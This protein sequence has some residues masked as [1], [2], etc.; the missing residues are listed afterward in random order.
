MSCRLFCVR[1]LRLLELPPMFSLSCAVLRRPW[2]RT[3]VTA[4]FQRLQGVYWAWTSRLPVTASDMF[5]PGRRIFS[6]SSTFYTIRCPSPIFLIPLLLGF[7]SRSP[8]MLV[9]CSFE[10]K[11]RSG[12][13]T[14]AGPG[15][16]EPADMA[17]PLWVRPCCTCPSYPALTCRYKL[18]T[19][20]FFF[21]FLNR[22]QL[23]GCTI[24]FVRA[25]KISR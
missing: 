11:C 6:S 16:R 17:F 18:N 7:L 10:C 19:E 3:G 23:S 5:P 13:D 2:R 1:F 14:A 20:A 8:C 24:V 15:R 9:T 4:C 12:S 22:L 21:S 25:C